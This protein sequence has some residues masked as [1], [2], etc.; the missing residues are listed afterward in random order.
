[1]IIVQLNKRIQISFLFKNLIKQKLS[2]ICSQW[3]TEAV[4]CFQ[5]V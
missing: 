5:M 1:M 2:L 3:Y 4:V